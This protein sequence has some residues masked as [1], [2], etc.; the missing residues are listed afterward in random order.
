MPLLLKLIPYSIATD[1]AVSWDRSRER[2][3][4]QITYKMW[5]TKSQECPLTKGQQDGCDSL[6][7]FSQNNTTG[8]SFLYIL[9]LWFL[10]LKIHLQ[11]VL[12]SRSKIVKRQN[13]HLGITEKY[14]KLK[15]K[16]FEFV[17]IWKINPSDLWHQNWDERTQ[18]TTKS[19]I[20]LTWSRML[21][22][23]TN[24]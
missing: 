9:E 23:M 5:R 17:L 18:E 13:Q 14:S 2:L 20:V 8:F 19:A 4:C 11:S 21:Q 15:P 10:I 12:T 6:L 3:L 16:Q 1:W 7:L 24:E 22:K